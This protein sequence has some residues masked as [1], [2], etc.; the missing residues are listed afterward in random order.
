[1]S[2]KNETR[3]GRPS[4]YR[5]EMA[6]Q[7]RKLCLLGATD[8]DLADFFDVAESTLNGWKSR[9]PEFLEAIRAGKTLAD[10]EVA[11]SLY[12]RAVGYSHEAVKIMQ[13]K[14]KPVEVPFVQHYPP[15]SEAARFWLTNRQRGRWTNTRSVELKGIL[16]HLS[17]AQLAPYLTDDQLGR[18]A[19]GELIEQVLA[20]LGSAALA[21]IEAE[22]GRGP[23]LDAEILDD[24]VE[25]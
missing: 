25:G 10:A 4:L 22:T 19:S 24:D 13:H 6:E 2:S 8:A 7:A 20:E 17:M 18:I 3:G 16:A 5:P 12:E 21:R 23:T 15:D 1:M 9:Y 14:G 11:R